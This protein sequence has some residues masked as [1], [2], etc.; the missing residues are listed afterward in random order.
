MTVKVDNPY[1]F[2]FLIRTPII[3]WYV[4]WCGCRS[5]YQKDMCLKVIGLYVQI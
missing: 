4:V 2:T 3:E 5:R 1:L